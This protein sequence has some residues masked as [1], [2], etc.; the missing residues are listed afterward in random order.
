[1]DYELINKTVELLE[2]KLG[3]MGQRLWEVYVKQSIIDGV[4]GTVVSWGFMVLL[5]Y[6]TSRV[7]KS[8]KLYEDDKR[9]FVTTMAML[10][11]AA[12][13]FGLLYVRYLINPEYFAV[14]RLLSHAVP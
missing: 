13:V 2:E 10:T 7:M 1:M 12:F 3:P 6:G 9:F 8:E 5:L 11:V 4:I 14:Q